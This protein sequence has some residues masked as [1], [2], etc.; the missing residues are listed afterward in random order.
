MTDY[1]FVYGTLM[2]GEADNEIAPIVK[3]LRRIGAAY[4][5]GRLYN[6]GEYPGAVIDHS[7]NTSVH[8]ELVELPADK[9]IL[10]AL[11]KYEEF[12]PSRPQKSL[13]IR[14]KTRIRLANGRNV[15]GWMYVYNRNPGNA[16]IIRG[17]NYSKSEVA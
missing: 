5:R 9:A 2:P 7:A 13:F 3:R 12:D 10:D 17:G 1:L 15:E 14:K 4:V 6:F 8:G 11:D 16:P